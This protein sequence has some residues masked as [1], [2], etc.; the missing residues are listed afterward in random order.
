MGQSTQAKTNQLEDQQQR[1][2][3]NTFGNDSSQAQARG[4]SEN[5]GAKSRL[6][7]LSTG[8]QG[9]ADTGGYDPTGV[10]STYGSA[11]GGFGGSSVADSLAAGGGV[12]ESKFSD[13]LAGYKSLAGGGGVDAD[14]IRA[15]ANSVIPSFYKNLQNDAERR[16]MVNP[17]APSF[18]AETAARS[19]QAGQDTQ[20][21]VRDTEL[22][23][24]DLITKNKV[25]GLAGLSGLETGIADLG[26]RGKIAGGEQQL[27]N[28]NLAADSARLNES[29]LGRLTSAESDIA[30]RSQ[31]GRLAGLEGLNSLYTTQNQNAQ[32]E[33]NRQ[34]QAHQ[35]LNETTQNAISGRQN[36]TPWWKSALKWAG[37]TVTAAAGAGGR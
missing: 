17:Y 23:I 4:D 15:R 33:Y 14:A 22:G 26:L 31:T 20:T 25:T 5:A 3:H 13:S 34:L 18:D 24:S 36:I 10:R 27:G 30:S 29:R 28:A 11:Y 1:Q 16:R 32:N 21:N 37:N 6:P 35:G 12:D 9:F 19:R 7:G 8:Y 2:A